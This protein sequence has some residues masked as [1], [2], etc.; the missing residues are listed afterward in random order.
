MSRRAFTLIEIAIA[1]GLLVFGALTFLNVFS[2]SASFSAQ[3]RNRTVATILAQN[4]LE[5][6]EAHPYGAPAPLSW[7]E[8]TETPTELWLGGRRQQ[9]KFHKRFEYANGSFVGATDDNEDLVTVTIT[10]REGPGNVENP[11][12]ISGHSDDQ[13]SLQVQVP[14]WR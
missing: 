12:P 14:V 9:M 5:E 1:C 2:S 4:L 13:K 3:S 8:T 6:I 11:E 10:W 7:G